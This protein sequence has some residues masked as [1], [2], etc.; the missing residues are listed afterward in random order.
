MRELLNK[1]ADGSVSF[2][3][4]ITLI[5]ESVRALGALSF[6]QGGRIDS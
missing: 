1:R 3:A 4:V 6:D 2:S 5:F